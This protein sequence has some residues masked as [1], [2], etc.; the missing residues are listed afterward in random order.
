MDKLWITQG[1]IYLYIVVSIYGQQDMEITTIQIG[2]ETR[3]LLRKVGRKEQTY[4]DLLRELVVRPNTC[5][6]C[7]EAMIED[8]SGYG[9]E[10]P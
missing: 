8:P 6:R 4:D 10:Q 5:E 9:I 3:Q 7:G 1:H 2:K